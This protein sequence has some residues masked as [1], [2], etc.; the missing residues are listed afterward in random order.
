MEDNR[1]LQCTVT[2]ERWPYHTP[3]RI[4][5]GVETD[6]A[7]IVVRLTNARGQTGWGEAS[8]VDYEENPWNR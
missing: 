1:L 5:R 6:L 7:V 4:A 2:T 3:F 8:G